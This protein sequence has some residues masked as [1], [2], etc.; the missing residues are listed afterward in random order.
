MQKDNKNLQANELTKLPLQIL[1]R[2]IFF[3]KNSIIMP[4]LTQTP[5][6]SCKLKQNFKLERIPWNTNERFFIQSWYKHTC[7]FI[8]DSCTFLEIFLYYVLA[9]T[10]FPH[11]QFILACTA[12]NKAAW[13]HEINASMTS[14]NT[15]FN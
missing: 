12:T 13:M 3:P 8:F 5:S 10:A 1:S 15:Q 4:L 11:L 6:K 14:K 9:H 2:F 7:I